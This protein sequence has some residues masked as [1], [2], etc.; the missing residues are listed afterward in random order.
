MQKVC[1]SKDWL[2]TGPE[3]GKWESVDLPHDYAISQPRDPHAPGGGS[4]G[5]FQGENGRYVKFFKPEDSPHLILDLDGAYM[6]AEVRLNGDLLAIHPY[7]YTPFLVELTD[8]LI[9]GTNK[10][11]IRT[12]GHQPSTRWY[13]GAGIYRDVFLWSGGTDRTEPWDGFITTPAA[14]EKQAQVRVSYEIRSDLDGEALVC[15]EIPGIIS[16]STPVKVKAGEKTPLTLTLTVENPDL[17]TPETPSLYQLHTTISVNGQVTDTA[18]N[19]FG[20]RTISFDATHGFRL[21]GKSR[22]M[23][24]GCIH[25]DHGVLGAMAFPAAE[26]RKL[27]LLKEAGFDAVRIAHNPPSLALLEVCDRIGMMV[28]DEAFDM[29]NDGKNANDYHLWFAD[30]C[31]R[32]ISYMVKRDRNH[33][34]VM[35]Y[36]IGN[37]IKERDGKSDGAWWSEKLA[38]EV[39]KYDTTRPV[40]SGICGSWHFREHIDPDDYWDTVSPF[41]CDDKENWFASA[42]WADY[43]QGYMAPLDIVGYNY[44]YD[45]YEEDHVRFPDRVIWGSETH[46]LKFYHSWNTVKRLPY[47]IGDFTWTA[48]DNLGETGTGRSCWARDGHIPGISVAGYPWRSCYQGDLDLCGYRRPQSYFRESVW[49]GSTEPKIFTTHPEHYGE[50]FSGTGWHWYDVLDTWTFEDE[51]LGK[52]VKAEVYTDADEILW[53]L[54]GRELGTSKPE[55]G[56]ATFDIPYEKGTLSV[57]AMKNGTECGCSSLHTVGSP[58]QISVIPEKEGLLANNRDLCYFRITVEDA[59]GNR[60]PNARDALTCLVDGGELLGIFSGDPKNEDQYTSNRCHAFEGRALAVVRTKN[61]GA[62]TVTVGAKNLRNGMAQVTAL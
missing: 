37:E 53:Y 9:G 39:R 56:I 16:A 31:M 24:G 55:N 11:D 27:R 29:W 60:V 50:G 30:W 10:L 57:K 51:Y 3:Y 38:D 47:V 14:D 43:T 23:R 52:P 54:N 18:D 35:S 5:F 41:Y 7:G 49:L 59:Q 32:D 2:F 26:E 17:W 21:N 20:I 58:A 6:N 44:W 13:S 12:N 19:T 42:K 62:V 22:K 36:S 40:T 48:I 25:H 61:P 8:K 33:P 4:N 15:A 34:C 1:I 46:T 45:R 28:M